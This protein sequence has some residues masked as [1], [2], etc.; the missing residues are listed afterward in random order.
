MIRNF[1]DE[2]NFLRKLLITDM[3]VSKIRKNFENGLSANIQLWE[4]QLPKIEK[5][6]GV[7]L[8]IPTSGNISSSVAK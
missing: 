5:L 2:T 6:W 1:N 7:L 8:D 3:Q 4:I